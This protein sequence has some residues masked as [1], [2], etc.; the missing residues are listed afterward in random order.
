[1]TIVV[2]ALAGCGAAQ[3]PA[4]TAPGPVATAPTTSPTPGTPAAAAWE[5][6]VGPQGEYAAAAAYE[7]VIER[8]GNVEPYVSIHRAE[9]MHVAALVRQ[10]E[11]MGVSPPPNPWTG[12]IPAPDSLQAAAR[13]WADG[14]VAN[15]A[16]YDRLLTRTDGDTALAR[17]F[18]N[19]RRASEQ[20]HL[21]LFRRAAENGGTIPADQMPSMGGMGAGAN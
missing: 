11:R 21:P 15:I 3:E 6:L 7:A 14:E 20:S 1:M 2:A 19:L 10:L 13:A 5:A 9:L 18:T 8:Y 4:D 12:R 17:V 16:L